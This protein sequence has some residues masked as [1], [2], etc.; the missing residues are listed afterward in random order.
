[1]LEAGLSLIATCLPIL[2][3]LFAKQSLQSVIATVRNVISLDT[4]RSRNSQTFKQCGAPY[5][6][7]RANPSR[8]SSQATPALNQHQ[9]PDGTI[10]TVPLAD[11]H[12]VHMQ[13]KI[14]NPD[15]TV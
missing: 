10:V 15:Y 2:R 7:I 13:S 8:A 12:K 6:E 1:M 5:T 9:R 14:R 11:L 3:P 4:L